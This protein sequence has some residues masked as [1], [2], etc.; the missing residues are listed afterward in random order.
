MRSLLPTLPA[1]NPALNTALN[2]QLYSSGIQML[3]SG[4][5]LVLQV[6]LPAA[7]AGRANHMEFSSD[8]YHLAVAAST[9][10]LAVFTVAQPSGTAPTG[11]LTLVAQLAGEGA[12]LWAG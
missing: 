11:E 6:A 1:L 3:S 8:G 5:G 7:V 4:R 9:G 10:A 2:P 12:V